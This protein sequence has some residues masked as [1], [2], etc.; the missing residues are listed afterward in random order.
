MTPTSTGPAL[1]GVLLAAVLISPAAV[2]QVETV[3]G[4]GSF[5]DAPI[6]PSGE[7]SDTIRPKETLYYAVD[8]G[9]GQRLVTKVFL[10]KDPSIPAN[11]G[12]IEVH[13]HNP[14]RESDPDTGS[15]L[16]PPGREAFSRKVATG[17]V[18]GSETRDEI[19][20]SQPGAYFLVVHFDDDEND[21]GRRE[22]NI[23]MEFKV[24]GR[25]VEPSPPASPTPVITPEPTPTEDDPPQETAE[26]PPDEGSAAPLVSIYLACFLAGLLGGGAWAGWRALRAG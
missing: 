22:V 12:S 23:R 7:Y 26:G 6:L 4:G 10:P 24:L 2:G 21:V 18:G 20:Y 25:A 14:L 16:G 8:L 1:L 11:D 9:I 5:N 3:R 19:Y 17:R 13:I 15:T